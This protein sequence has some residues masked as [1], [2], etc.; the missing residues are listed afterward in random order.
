MLYYIV[1]DNMKEK[2]K[3]KFK[4][5]VFPIFISVLSGSVCGHLVF[6]IYE[7]IYFF[8]LKQWFMMF[9]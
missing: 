9:N 6:S 1:G 8:V 4:K 7:D 5:V 2:I 3:T